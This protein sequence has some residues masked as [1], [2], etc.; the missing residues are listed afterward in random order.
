MVVKSHKSLLTDRILP[1]EDAGILL[2]KELGGTWNK[3]TV[4]RRINASEP[5]YWE[6][7]YHYMTLGKVL[8]ALNVDAIKRSA[9]NV[10]A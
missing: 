3:R 7:G 4:R 10:A 5:F 6:E 2:E 8:T 1:V 9:F